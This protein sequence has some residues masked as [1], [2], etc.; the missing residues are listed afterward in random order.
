[1]PEN[2]NTTTDTDAKLTEGEESY[3]AYAAKIKKN[4]RIRYAVAITAAAAVTLLAVKTLRTP[5]PDEE[6]TIEA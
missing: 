3:A 5:V 6:E 2:I 4:K 1:M